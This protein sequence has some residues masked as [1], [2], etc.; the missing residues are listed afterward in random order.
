M[1]ENNTLLGTSSRKLNEA[2]NRKKKHSVQS[3]CRIFSYE[4][5]FIT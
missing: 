4:S 5:D 2:P 1:V 3:N